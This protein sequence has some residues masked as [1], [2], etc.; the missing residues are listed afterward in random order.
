V[1]DRSSNGLE[2]R[3]WEIQDRP[4]LE[5]TS[6][7]PWYAG[8][9][10]RYSEQAEFFANLEGPHQGGQYMTSAGPRPQ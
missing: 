8:P 5:E 6:E 4:L 10:I 3:G 2:E 7:P 9:E 1:V